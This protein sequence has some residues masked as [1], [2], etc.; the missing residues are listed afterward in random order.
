[1]RNNYILQY[2]TKFVGGYSHKTRKVFLIAQKEQAKK[3]NPVTANSFIADH[4]NKG[5]SFESEHVTILEL[6]KK[7]EPHNKEK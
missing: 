4:A 3:F 7:V 1:M 2:K 5:R 6:E